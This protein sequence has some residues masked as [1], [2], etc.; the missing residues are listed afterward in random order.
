MATIGFI[1]A[2]NCNYPSTNAARRVELNTTERD[3]AIAFDGATSQSVISPTMAVQGIETPLSITLMVCFPVATSGSAVF[4][5]SVMAVSG[6]DAINLATTTSYDSVNT[7][8]AINAP[9][10]VNNP[11]S[12]TITLTNADGVAALDFVKIKITRNPANGSDTIAT[13]CYLISAILNDA[14]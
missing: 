10:S 4:D 14:R 1:S 2:T 8:A 13:D 9:A 6:G 7:S 3:L 11:V 12:A 5:V